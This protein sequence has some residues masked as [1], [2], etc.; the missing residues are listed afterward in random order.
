MKKYY[1]KLVRDKIPEIIEAAGKRAEIRIADDSEYA[2]LL[3]QKL[4]EEVDEYMQSTNPD[5]LADI[6][7]VIISLGALHNLS[8]DALMQIAAGKREKRGGFEKGI[9]LLSVDE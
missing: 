3:R 4:L 1:N 2:N 5:E 8:V 6:I 9:V 7:E